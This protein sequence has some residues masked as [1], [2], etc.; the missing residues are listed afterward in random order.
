MQARQF[1]L[2]ISRCVPIDITLDDR[3]A[4]ARLNAELTRYAV[5]RPRAEEGEKVITTRYG[6]GVDV[7]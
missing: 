5:K 7:C 6:V 3:A 1:D 4:A 2:K